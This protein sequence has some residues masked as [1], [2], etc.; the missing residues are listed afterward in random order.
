MLGGSGCLAGEYRL[1]TVGQNGLLGN[2]NVAAA[3]FGSDAA[4]ADHGL[5]VSHHFTTTPASNII[6]H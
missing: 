6:L 2:G 4:S 1:Y 3:V 5:R